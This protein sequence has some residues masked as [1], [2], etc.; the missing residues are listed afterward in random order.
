M[1]YLA[2]AAD[3]LAKVVFPISRAANVLG[4][5]ALVMIVIVTVAEIISRRAFHAPITGATEFILLCFTLVIF[6]MLAKC[7]M[8]NGHLVVSLLTNALPK[9]IQLINAALMHIVT[10]GILSL[11]SWQ[12][13]VYAGRVQGMG[14][15]AAI[16]NVPIYP[17]VYL[18]ALAFILLTLV[19]LIKL[20]HSISEVRQSW[21]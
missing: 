17:F 3:G 13:L 21:N 18:A 15:T 10:I 14:Q 1:R 7:A 16:I 11:A 5:A 19:Y 20:L 2:R 8:E 9:R 6:M 4:T 12:L